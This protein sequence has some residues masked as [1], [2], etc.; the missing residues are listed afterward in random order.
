MSQPKDTLSNREA[1]DRFWRRSSFHDESIEE[2][3]AINK[4]VLLR[5]TEWTLVVTGASNLIRCE[6][7]AVWLDQSIVSK[8]TGFLLDVET[9][10]GPL[11]VAGLDFRL[12]R[13]S[14]LAVV[15]PAIDA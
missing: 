9:D 6:L 4:R 7:P 14:D 13:N 1:L 12:I 15:I 10:Q 11:K 8:G 2:I 3:K 5:L